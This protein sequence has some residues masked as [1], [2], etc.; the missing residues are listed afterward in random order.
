[1]GA[2]GR[3]AASPEGMRYLCYVEK[4]GFKLFT[5]EE[6]VKEFYDPIAVREVFE[7]YLASNN[8]LNQ[9]HR[10]RSGAFLAA[11]ETQLFGS[12][13][14][15]GNLIGLNVE[16]SSK[17]V[18]HLRG[19][20]HDFGRFEHESGIDIDNSKVLS[21][22][23]PRDFLQKDETGDSGKALITVR[24]MRA[25][26]AEIGRAQ[27]GIANGV[28]QNISI[29]VPG[30]ALLMRNVNPAENHGAPAHQR[31]NIITKTYTHVPNS[32]LK[33]SAICKSLGV[34]I[35]KFLSSPSTHT[36]CPPT[37]SMSAASSVA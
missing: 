10:K 14:F 15:D 16:G 18:A 22:Q 13:R 7:R 26:I 20:A 9:R 5:A 34:V 19:I 29:R 1:M 36:T 11:N 27:Q 24:K 12:C 37:R 4:E 30:K 3:F 8:R 25:E 2:T 6:L 23:Q 17:I 28:T 32:W 21:S 31:M 35:F 33:S